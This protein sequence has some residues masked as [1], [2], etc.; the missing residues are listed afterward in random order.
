MKDETKI[1]CKVCDRLVSKNDEGICP[2]CN[3]NYE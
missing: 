2:Y 3:E 1:E